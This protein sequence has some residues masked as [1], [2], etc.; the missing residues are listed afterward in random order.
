MGNLA[1]DL[2]GL[3]GAAKTSPKF[4]AYVETVNG[5]EYD[6][7]LCNGVGSAL[8]K[9]VSAIS[10]E[11]TTAELEMLF[12]ELKCFGSVVEYL[13]VYALMFVVLHECGHVM[14]GH[15]RFLLQNTKSGERKHHFS[16]MHA[17]RTSLGAFSL[18]NPCLQVNF[19]K[20]IEMEADE[21][22][23]SVMMGAALEIVGSTGVIPPFL[24]GVTCRS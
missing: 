5:D 10:S 4:D 16:E 13:R 6:I 17:N 21:F 19:S 7:V 18:A 3:R 22:A 8:D 15:F 1:S 24:T 23:F 12:Q 20:L 2:L 14:N 9:A 11:T